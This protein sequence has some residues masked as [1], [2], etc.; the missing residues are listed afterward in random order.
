MRTD[1][2]LASHEFGPWMLVTCR[3]PRQCLE[4]RSKLVRTAGLNTRHAETILH[5]TEISMMELPTPPV[6]STEPLPHTDHVNQSSSKPL[7]SESSHH[8][9]L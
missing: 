1:K 4:A 5:Q 7:D 6:R 8:A 9:S 2:D 3:T